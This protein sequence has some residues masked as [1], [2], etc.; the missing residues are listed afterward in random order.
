MRLTERLH[1]VGGAAPGPANS[2]SLDAQVYAI[3]T[4]DGL[5]VVDSGAGRSIERLLAEVRSS[6]LDPSAIRWLL[7]THGHGD[8]AGGAAA[9]KRAV[10]RVEVLASADVASWL[11]A[12]DEEATS[13]D[14]ARRAG[15]YPSDYRLEPCAAVALPGDRLRLG[16]ID[17]EIVPTPGHAAGHLSFGGLI[18]GAMTVFTGDALLPGGRILLQDTWDCDLHAALRSVERLAALAPERMLGGHLA[19]IVSDARRHVDRA[20]DRIARLLPPEQLE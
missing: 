8:H 18:D 10:P 11:V 3:D 6:G 14:R 4:G 19:P 12:G 16:A 9:W 13:V 1:L 5:A 2:D 15:I 20:L 7:L 17:L